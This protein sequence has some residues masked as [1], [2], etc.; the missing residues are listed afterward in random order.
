MQHL[1]NLADNPNSALSVEIEQ[2]LAVTPLGNL[3]QM[4]NN[5]LP[6]HSS[7]RTGVVIEPVHL[8]VGVSRE[9]VDL[10]LSPG[11]HKDWDKPV[12]EAAPEHS[13]AALSPREVVGILL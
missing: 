12:I 9:A 13:F 10:L 3:V 2:E 5:P 6:N 8:F 4:D 7:T 1:E 11:G